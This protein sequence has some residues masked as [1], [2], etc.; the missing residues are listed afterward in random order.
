MSSS[1]S[2]TARPRGR[3]IQGRDA[4]AA[5]G[6][7]RTNARLSPGGG[8]ELEGAVAEHIQQEAHRAGFDAGYADGLRAAER[9]AAVAEVQRVQ[10]V[11]TLRRAFGDAGQAFEHALQ[12]A[13][14]DL[15]DALAT[16]SIMLAEAIIGRE[17]AVAENPG[18]DA[19]ARALALAPQ[20]VPIIAKLHP[21]DLERLGDPRVLFG[22]RDIT[23]MADPNVTPGGCVMQV[24]RTEI[25]AQLQTAVERARKALCG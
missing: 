25:D 3:V 24:A 7:E 9:A 23:V 10:E 8:L 19:I 22:D 20:H 15:E 18:K 6:V 14:G 2:P 21:D 5:R 13:L 11:E 4:N 16:A 12:Q 17:L 1:S